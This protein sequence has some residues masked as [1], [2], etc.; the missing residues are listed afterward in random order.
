MSIGEKIRA[1]RE[2]KGLT[3]ED[4]GKLCGTTK[5]TI[6]KYETGVITNIPL[7]RLELIA[8]ALSTTA[9]DLMGWTAKPRLE[10][11]LESLSDDQL[12]DLLQRLT[13]KLAEKRA[14]K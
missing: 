5:Q 14:D 3:L 7:D 13:A 1:L 9:A 11:Y 4:L 10:E 8:D 12:L 2:Q 6:Y